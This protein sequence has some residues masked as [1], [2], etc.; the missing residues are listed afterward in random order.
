M[1]NCSSRGVSEIEAITRLYHLLNDCA[2]TSCRD[3]D[4][5]DHFS[6]TCLWDR[7]IEELIIS[8]ATRG[9]ACPE[10]KRATGRGV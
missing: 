8:F 7:L 10:Q 4:D 1:F 9:E 2:S 3:N 6:G 5:V